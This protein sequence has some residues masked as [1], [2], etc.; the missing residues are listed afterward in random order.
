M[1]LCLTTCAIDIYFIFFLHQRVKML[2]EIVNRNIKIN[3]LCSL[4]DIYSKV[5]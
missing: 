1:R 3:G 2:I 5:R 4:Y